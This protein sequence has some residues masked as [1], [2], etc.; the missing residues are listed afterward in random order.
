MSPL[1]RETVIVELALR[2]VIFPVTKIIFKSIVHI[3]YNPYL[4]SLLPS[5]SF[6]SHMLI[7]ISL[8]KIIMYVVTCDSQCCL[9][10]NVTQLVLFFHHVTMKRALWPQFTAP[11]ERVT[12]FCCY[13]ELADS[14]AARIL[15]FPFIFFFFVFLMFVVG[16]G[17]L[18]WGISQQHQS[19]AGANK[20]KYLVPVSPK[21]TDCLKSSSF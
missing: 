7:L 21:S 8:S 5:A 15:S 16:S 17:G 18:R 20:K 9:L 3:Y 1:D 10:P 14:S 19:A 13:T 2:Y 12:S 4:D 11:A 6:K